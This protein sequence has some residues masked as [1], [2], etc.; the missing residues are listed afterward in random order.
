MDI[1]KY[2]RKINIKRHF[3]T[4]PV[5]Q[6]GS[7]QQ[8]QHSGLANALT[9]NPP[10]G[11]LAPSLKVFRDVMLRD[12]ESIK[13]INPKMDNQLEEGLD[14]LCNNKDLI[15]HPA[16]KGG[17]IVVLDWKDYLQQV[18]DVENDR[19]IY[20]PLLNNPVIK[21]KHALKSLV[22]K[23][24]KS[25]IL[26]EKESLFLIPKAPRV[27]VLYCLPKIHKSLTCPPG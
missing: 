2:V 11:V 7:V 13:S 27:P 24:V 23:G 12:L 8:Y 19:D 10:S 15:V 3:A 6:A 18:Y 22:E 1:H 20:I 21:Y 16:N 4:I 26:N 9:F 25:C 14:S 17:G 5:R